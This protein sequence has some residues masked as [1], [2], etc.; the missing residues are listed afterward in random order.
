M[1]FQNA[2]AAAATQDG[3]GADYGTWELAPDVWP[4]PT[5]SALWK[6]G[7]DKIFRPFLCAADGGKSRFGR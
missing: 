2:A 4:V 7:M 3:E 1:K 6:F 5:G